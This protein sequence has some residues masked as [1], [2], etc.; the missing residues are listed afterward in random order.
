MVLVHLS[1]VHLSDV[2]NLDRLG[3]FS[4]RI[5]NAKVIR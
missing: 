3:H 5:K 1:P 4:D 2:M